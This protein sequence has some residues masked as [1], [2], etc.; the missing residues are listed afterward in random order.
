MTLIYRSKCVNNDDG[1]LK[2]PV[3]IEGYKDRLIASLDHK[4][5][6]PAPG[7]ALPP[8][9]GLCT[10]NCHRFRAIFREKIYKMTADYLITELSGPL[11]HYPD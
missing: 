3:Y 11:V 6:F 1:L 9:L 4:L 10:V 5:S 8:L 2:Y 7:L